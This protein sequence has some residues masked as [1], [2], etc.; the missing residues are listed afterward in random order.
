MLEPI[1]I[2][3]LLAFVLVLAWRMS[4]RKSARVM[5]CLCL[6]YAIYEYL[7]YARVL[8]SGDCNIRIDLV[9]IYP[10][11]LT[12]TLWA[13]ASSGWHIFKRGRSANGD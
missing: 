9:L 4:Q 1:P 6:L 11:L 8:C 13:I 3:I 12:G 7:M 5:A 2:A 10:L